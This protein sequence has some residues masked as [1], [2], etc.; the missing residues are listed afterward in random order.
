MPRRRLKRDDVQ[1]SSGKTSA[2]AWVGLAVIGA[3]SVGLAAMAL[4]R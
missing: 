3:I 1:G 4:L 2:A